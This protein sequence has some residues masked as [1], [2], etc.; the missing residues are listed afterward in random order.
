MQLGNKAVA[1]PRRRKLLSTRRG[2]TLVAIGAAVLAALLL[3][4]FLNHYKHTL[5]DTSLQKAVVA[6]R[7]IPKGASADVLAR[8]GTTLK[9]TQV[10]HNQLKTG[11]I[12]DTSQ[13]QGL[14]ATRDIYPGEQITSSDFTRSAQPILTQVQAAD[15]AV[16]V[17]LD[18]SHGLEGQAKAGDYVDVMA[19]FDGTNNTGNQAAFT[20]LII[21]DV[22]VLSA[23]SAAKKTSVVG[24]SANSTQDVVL[25]VSRRDITTL[26]FAADNGKVWLALRPKTGSQD[27]SVSTITISRLLAGSKPV[28]LPTPTSKG[29]HR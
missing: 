10:R 21:P 19:S 4:L 11:A 8:D 13:L 14:V 20:R 27:P 12:T 6:D 17:S 18:S 3:A 9:P 1:L 16:A 2:T 29:G 5:T 24:N 22:L 28:Q 26:A 15:R 25:R 7:L 23:P